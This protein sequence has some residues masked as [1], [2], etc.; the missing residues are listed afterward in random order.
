M[1]PSADR[2]SLSGLRCKPDIF[3]SRI[4]FIPKFCDG[5]RLL[6]RPASVT[7]V[8]LAKATLVAFATGAHRDAW[9]RSGDAPSAD[10]SARPRTAADA[11][12]ARGAGDRAPSLTSAD[13]ARTRGVGNRSPSLTV[14]HRG[15]LRSFFRAMPTTVALRCLPITVGTL[16]AC[17]SRC[18]LALARPGRAVMVL[19]VFLCGRGGEWSVHESGEW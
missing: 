13:A 19:G 8:V 12:H 2:C 18:P 6:D 11:A 7:C 9:S 5:S 16:C 15:A 3:F 10:G 14:S 1:G 17:A 4:D